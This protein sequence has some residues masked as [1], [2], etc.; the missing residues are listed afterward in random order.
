MCV[1]DLH[2]HNIDSWF[3]M[4]NL[5]IS[6]SSKDNRCINVNYIYWTLNMKTQQRGKG[7]S[8][9]V[10]LIQTRL[11]GLPRGLCSSLDTTADMSPMIHSG[12]KRGK[13]GL[14]Y[15]FTCSWLTLTSL[16]SCNAR[17][18]N[19]SQC[20]VCSRGGRW[21][22]GELEA[23]VL[24]IMSWKKQTHYHHMQVSFINTHIQDSTWCPQ[25]LKFQDTADFYQCGNH[26]YEDNMLPHW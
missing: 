26:K 3:L 8:T 19:D 6:V 25:Q 21:A 23:S 2:V 12:T 4:W 17:M 1:N 7:L 24:A 22:A 20:L 13:G 5:I 15:M 14:V 9:T 11:V 10:L 16:K 18:V